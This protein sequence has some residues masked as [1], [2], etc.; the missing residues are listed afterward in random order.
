MTLRN[1]H[2]S[3][4]GIFRIQIYGEMSIVQTFPN[5]KWHMSIGHI[6]INFVI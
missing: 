4:F 6:I 3:A 5:A 2:Y 1:I